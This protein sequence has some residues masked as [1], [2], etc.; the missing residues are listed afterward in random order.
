MIALAAMLGVPLPDDLRHE[1]GGIFDA[2]I[3]LAN[4]AVKL[5]RT[6]DVS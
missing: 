1:V 2:V 6:G 4:R 5:V 3:F